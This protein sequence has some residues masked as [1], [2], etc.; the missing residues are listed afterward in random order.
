VKRSR[1][2][3]KGLEGVVVKHGDYF[4]PFIEPMM[5]GVK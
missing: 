5:Q 3:G 2:G 1:E 4:N